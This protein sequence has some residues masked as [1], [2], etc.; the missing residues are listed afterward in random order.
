MFLWYLVCECDTNGTVKGSNIC[1][2]KT[3]ACD[4]IPGCR[5][6]FVGNN[7]GTCPEKYASQFCD[8]CKDEHYGYPDCHHCECLTSH[9]KNA[10]NVCEKENGTCPCTK[11]FTGRQCNECEVGYFGYPDCK[12]L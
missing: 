10:S 4:K 11:G 5:N 3:G 2:K 8:S 12:G 1:D 6:Q 7:C 9:T